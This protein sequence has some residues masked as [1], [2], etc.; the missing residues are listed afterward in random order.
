MRQHKLTTILV[1]G[2]IAVLASS[3]IAAMPLKIKPKT[4]KK[5][6]SAPQE[7][8]QGVRDQTQTSA[9]VSIKTGTNL[10]IFEFEGKG[11]SV[12]LATRMTEE[13]RS[14]VRR[15]NIFQV[16]DRGLTQ[17]INILRPESDR[18]SVV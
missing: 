15:L 1:H 3:Q 16:Q 14:T 9:S 10:A 11:I 7:T 13:F 8:V 18:K 4:Y 17:R 2:I 5:K 12:P 6:K